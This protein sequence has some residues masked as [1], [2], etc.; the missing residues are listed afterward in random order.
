[1]FEF[2]IN[3]LRGESKADEG[4]GKQ[5]PVQPERPVGERLRPAVEVLEDRANPGGGF[6]GG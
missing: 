5:A 6:W 4:P 3:L 2:L 1:M